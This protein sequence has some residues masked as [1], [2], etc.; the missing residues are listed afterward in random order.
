MPDAL[1]PPA[2]GRPVSPVALKSLRRE[3]RARRRGLSPLEQR[4]HAA[5]LTRALGRD[6]RFLRARR[7]GAFWPA[8]GELDARP[9]LRR[10]H[11]RCMQTFLPVLRPGRQR[12]LWFVSYRP[13]APLR[14]NRLGIPEPSRDRR[15]LKLPWQLDLLLVPLVGFDRDCN[16]I[17]MGGGFYDRTLAYLRRR[18][19]WRRPYLMGIAH[20]CQR[21]ERIDPRPWDIPLDGIATEL[22]VYWRGP[23]AKGTETSWPSS[24]QP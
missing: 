17:G 6:L 18:T 3:L 22:G 5:A 4:L 12:R 24:P 15:H 20:E 21:I 23:R 9:L 10:A 2:V 1:Y 13:H 14:L 11:G 8:D 16:R 19:H 7:M